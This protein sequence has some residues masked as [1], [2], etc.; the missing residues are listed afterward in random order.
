MGLRL[1]ENLHRPARMCCR[2]EV[3]GPSGHLDAQELE[4]LLVIRAGDAVGAQQRTVID[5][6]SHHHEL[7]VLESQAR[8]PRGGERELC[9]GPMMYLEDALR[10]YSS[11]D[12]VTCRIFNGA[13]CYRTARRVTDGFSGL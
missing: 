6:E 7:P 3:S 1:I 5:V 9:I 10:S 2:R 13:E 11:Q 4:V 8:V 12:T